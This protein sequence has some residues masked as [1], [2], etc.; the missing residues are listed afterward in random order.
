MPE[1][2]SEEERKAVREFT[3][4]ASLDYSAIR[5][6]LAAEERTRLGLAERRETSRSASSSSIPSRDKKDPSVKT[7]ATTKPTGRVI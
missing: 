6:G 7:T 4:G 5:R 3:E 2:R 1:D